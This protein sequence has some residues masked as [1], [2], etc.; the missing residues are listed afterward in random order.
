M[1]ERRGVPLAVRLS[2]A[3][4]PD[5]KRMLQ[6]VEAVEPVRGQRRHRRQR[7]E[8]LHADQAYDDQGL[9]RGL[10]ERGIIPRIARR[11]LESRERLG[12]YGWVVERR[13]SWQQGFRRRRVRDEKRD[14][15]H[16][17]LVQL[18]NAMICWGRL[19]GHFC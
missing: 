3:N 6:R 4:L 18:A 2:G 17:A 14:D 12:G 15:I 1:V 7:P 8:R 10:R 9:R 13:L 19:N 5:G 16:E 11:G